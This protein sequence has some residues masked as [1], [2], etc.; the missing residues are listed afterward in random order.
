MELLP[1]Q[2]KY[3]RG[4]PDKAILAHEGGT[5]KSVCAS[6]W[7][8]DGRD[9]DA[10]V[11][12]T[13]RIVKKWEETL[14]KWDT[15]ATVWSKEQFK[16]EP[17]HKWSAIVV[18]EADEFAS[19]LFTKAR[20][21]LAT[22][23]YEQIKKYDCPILLL[24]ATPVR[25]NP[26]NLHS[27]LCYIGHYIDWKVW[28][29]EFFELSYLPYLPRPA[30]MPKPDWRSKMRPLL[31][32]YTD[33]VLLKDCVE[34]LPPVS[35]SVIT[36]KNEPFKCPLEIVTP[37]AKFVAQHKHEQSNKVKEIL[38]IAKDYRKV[39]VVAYYIEQL[40]ELAKQLGK[41]RETFMVH[42]G[43]KNQEDILKQANDSDECFLVVQASL[44]VGFDANTFSAIMFASMSYKVRDWVQM[45]FRVRRIHDL[46]P[47]AY[48]YLIGGRA[49]QN[50]YKVIQ[51]GKDFVPSEWKYE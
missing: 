14:K 8:H 26:W 7:L 45:K 34:Y 44:G 16:K 19:P 27:L 36:V 37:T 24:T 18:D 41:D 50:V 13:K 46:H 29:S 6:V 15:K 33:I 20:S 22:K 28:R 1:H 43:V 32:K 38:D 51:E 25:S 9:S 4:Y 2:I 12:C 35:E 31:Q 11:I 47:V 23:L 42:G 39:L 49:D 17:H 21:Q 10:L 48:Y 30:Y 3:A 5:G 40:E